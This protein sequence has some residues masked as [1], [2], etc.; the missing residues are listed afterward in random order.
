MRPIL[1]EIFGLEIPAWHSLVMVAAIM[2]Y[3]LARF[4]M[5]TSK[6]LHALVHLPTL[7]LAAYL[8]GWLGAR[9]LGIAL[10]EPHV[11][12]IVAF[13][14]ALFG[15]GPMVF[16]GGVIGGTLGVL[17][18]V[19]LKKLN[20]A[21][22]FDVAIPSVV[23]GLAIGRLGCFL[24]GC[25][26]GVPIKEHSHA[27]WAH[28]NPVLE[29]GLARY[30]TQLEESFFSIALALVASLVFLKRPEWV[31]NNRGALGA[32]A[33]ILTSA[34]RFANEFFRGDFR[35]QFFATPLS[36]SQGISLVLMGIGFI[37]LISVQMAGKI[38]DDKGI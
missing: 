36:T 32:I 9:A 22:L 33:L 20:L 10:E 26:Y 12:G 6:N 19:F 25:D 11:T 15:M 4:L 31:K 17:S 2:A 3:F 35:G 7:F 29:D 28:A 13:L 38:R 1:F 37:V 14:K 24:N 8:P 18:I 23:L 16:Y 34:N 5:A 27:W 30:P 21:A